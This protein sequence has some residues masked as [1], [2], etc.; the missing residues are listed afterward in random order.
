[1]LP[2]FIRALLEKIK[3]NF[4]YLKTTRPNI[5]TTNKSFDKTTAD[6]SRQILLQASKYIAPILICSKAEDNTQEFHNGTIFFYDTGTKVLGITAF[7]VYEK[8]LIAKQNNAL[9]TCQINEATVNLEKFYIDGDKKIDIATFEFDKNEIQKIRKEILTGNQQSWPPDLPL[10]GDTVFFAGFPGYERI[11]EGQKI[12]F[13]IYAAIHIIES[14]NEN[15]IICQVDKTQMVDIFG[16]GLPTDTY[17]LGG[18]SG[19]PIC[20]V[21]TQPVINWRLVGIIHEANK[22][23]QIIYARKINF[24]SLDGRLNKNLY[25]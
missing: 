12:N 10:K 19:A 4:S 15:D 21:S 2:Y 7:H 8:Y 3:K 22:N 25:L 18:L 24:I 5:V 6:I 1:M 14:I 20:V 9:I 11:V 17:D 13:G 16:K 23:L